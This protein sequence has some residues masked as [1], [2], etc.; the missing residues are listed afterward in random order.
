MPGAA[1]KP[2]LMAWLKSPIHALQPR[3]ALLKRNVVEPVA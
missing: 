1:K 3:G 2:L